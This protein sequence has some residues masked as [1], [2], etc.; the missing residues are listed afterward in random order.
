MRK[1]AICRKALHMIAVRVMRRSFRLRWG[2]KKRSVLRMGP[3]MGPPPGADPRKLNEKLKE[4][5]PKSIR[6]VPGYLW[7][8]LT[9]MTGRMCYIFR[10]VWDTRPWILFLMMFMAIYD[11]VMPV[12]AALISANLM[13]VLASCMLQKTLDGIYTALFLQFGYLI[14]NSIVNNLYNMLYRISGEMITN[15][16]KMKIMIKAKDVDVA[17]FDKPEFYE[18]LENANREAGMRP[19]QMLKSTFSIISTLITTLSFIAMT[20]GILP[21]API[22]IIAVSVPSAIINFVYR[23]KNFNYVRRRSVDRRQMSYY[24]NLMVDKDM[25]K[26]VR[27]FGLSDTFLKGYK[28]VFD[29]YFHGIKSLIYSE[30]AWNIALMLVSTAVNCW[31]YIKVAASVILGSGQIGDFSLYTGALN[32]IAGGISGLISTTA[33]IYE[34]TLFIDNL[35]LFMHE[36]KTIVPLDA[37]NPRHVR[38]HEAHTIEL[39]HVSFRY[40]GTDRDVLHDINLTLHAGDT[41]VLVGLNGAGK[42]TLIKLITRLYDP[43]EGVVLLDGHDI[44]E[45]DVDELYKMYGIIFQDFGKYAFSVADNISFGQ[46]EREPDETAIVDAARQSSADQFISRLPKGYETPLMRYFSEDGIELSIG[47]WQKLSIARAFYSDSDFLILDEPTASLDAIAEQ[48][49]FKQFDELRKDKTTIFVSHRLSSATVASKIIV[50]ENGR[51]VEEGNHREL[52]NAHG[53]YYELFSTQAKRYIAT[54][55]EGLIDTPEEQHAEKEKPAAPE[56]NS[57]S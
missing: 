4:P 8:V 26:E 11:G 57:Y 55:G 14:F 19:V 54:A 1:A 34:G 52:M 12:L 21:V 43:T 45:Y 24:S 25:V 18:R 3:M 7:R 40:P 5:K 33:T 17:S 15:S 28:N 20:A 27:L 30:S 6:E 38:R 39:R 53:R 36:K 50:L 32:S 41:C 35:I 22:L 9:G 23:K 29:R 44:R 46:I 48:E 37:Q 13:N 51:L 56:F 47:Q 2:Q 10:L 42:T 31:L 49:I 16:I